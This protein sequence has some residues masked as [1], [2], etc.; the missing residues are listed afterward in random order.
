[1]VQPNSTGPHRLPAQLLARYQALAC[2]SPDGGT[3]SPSKD[4]PN[5]YNAPQHVP[6][7]NNE[8]ARRNV[9]GR[10]ATVNNADI[11]RAWQASKTPMRPQRSASQ[12]SGSWQRI[13]P[14]NSPP[15]SRLARLSV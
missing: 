13:T 3:R 7:K 1:M 8:T 14:A 2:A 12:A 11:N 10:Q 6:N 15:T 5:G 9:S 4:S